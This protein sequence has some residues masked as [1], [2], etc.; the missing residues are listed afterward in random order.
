MGQRLNIEITKNGKVL[1]NAYYHW[2]GFT[3]SAI[4]LTTQILSRFEEVKK[5]VAKQKSSNKDLLLA[6]R[7]LELTGAG[8]DFKDKESDRVLTIGN[9]F[10]TMIDRNEGIIGVTRKQIE[11]TRNWEEARV[12]IDIATKI[13]WFGVFHS[14]EDNEK[15]EWI[16]KRDKISEDF[17]FPIYN[18]T[19]EQC[20]E[21]EKKIYEA[22]ENHCYC[23]YDDALG[24]Y[25]SMII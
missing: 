10:K 1:A 23:F 20:F 7:L 9:E 2:S 3:N 24:C 6:I 15:E 14:F 16:D 25:L 12:E 11:E 4:E 17:D 13:V 19:F 8:I 18:L 5:K 22:V 21:M